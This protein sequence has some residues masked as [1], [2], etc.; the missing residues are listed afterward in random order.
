MLALLM[1]SYI[2]A[3]T[4]TLPIEGEKT[5]TDELYVQVNEDVTGPMEANVVVTF[6]DGAIDFALNDFILRSEYEGEVDEMPVG[7]IYLPG[8]PV[9][10]GEDGIYTYSFHDTME[11][12]NGTYETDEWGDEVVWIGPMLGPLELGLD[13]K[14]TNDKVFVTIDIPLEA[15]EQ[16]IHV[17]FGK[18]DF[19]TAINELKINDKKNNTAAAFDLNGRVVSKTIK[20]QVYVIN[21]KKV[22]K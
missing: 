5:Y 18:D 9:V 14:I 22:L 2:C 8:L 20:G 11:I 13:G 15:L 21:G 12:T 3:Q 17:T 7:N 1:S 6:H 19:A 10:A 16:T 4:A